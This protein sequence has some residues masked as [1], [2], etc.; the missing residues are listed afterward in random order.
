MDARLISEPDDERHDR[1]RRLHVVANAVACYG[2][3]NENSVL[4]GV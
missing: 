1:D 4:V 2:R 3:R